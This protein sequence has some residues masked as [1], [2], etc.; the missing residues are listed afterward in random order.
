MIIGENFVFIHT[1]KAG[2]MSFTRW[3]VNNVDGPLYMVV[4][5]YAFEHTKEIALYDDILERMEIIEGNRHETLPE[6]REI[7]DKLK[8][9]EPEFVFAT[10]RDPYDLVHSAYSYLRKPHVTQRRAIQGAQN[11]HFDQVLNYSFAEFAKNCGFFSHS[12]DEVTSYFQSPKSFE[13]VDV[14]PL[15]DMS[16]YL[17][18]RFADHENFGRYNLERRNTSA[19]KSM[20]DAE[21]KS[22]KKIIYKRFHKLHD[23]YKIACAEAEKNDHWEVD[24]ARDAKIKTTAKR[25]KGEA[26]KLSDALISQLRKELANKNCQID[27]MRDNLERTNESNAAEQKQLRHDR[28]KTIEKRDVEIKRLQKDRN[29]KDAHIQLLRAEQFIRNENTKDAILALQSSLDLKPDQYRAHFLLG[30]AFEIS[31]DYENAEKHLLSALKINP[32]KSD[33]VDAVIQRVRAKL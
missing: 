21:K 2:G 29:K 33:I 13:N 20:D 31:Q 32:D 27:K 17:K 19:K 22:A 7:L 26:L 24:K 16:N 12:P 3:L 30:R 14:V 6:A 9:P 10:I 15:S 25:N 28:E 8:L 18:F 11:A 4:P 23:V 5:E 1:P